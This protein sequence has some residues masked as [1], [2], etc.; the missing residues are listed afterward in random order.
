MII[1]ILSYDN[2]GFLSRIF[3][4]VHPL[5]VT[6]IAKS[7]LQMVKPKLF[8]K[9]ALHCTNQYESKLKLQIAKG[10]LM[11]SRK[12]NAHIHDQYFQ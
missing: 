11:Y 1:K 12:S 2:F 4:V 6:I 3:N 10:L 7:T 9:F 5:N 8:N